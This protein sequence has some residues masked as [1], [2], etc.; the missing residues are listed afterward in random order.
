MP[1]T[2]SAKGRI[3]LLTHFL[4][5]SCRLRLHQHHTECESER[6]CEDAHPFW[7]LDCRFSIVEEKLRKKSVHSFVLVG[8]NPKSKIENYLMTLSARASTFGGIARPICLAVL[9]LMISSNFFGCS[10]GGSAG[11]GGFFVFF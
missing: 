11:G 3:L 2:L 9:R 8:F 5:P 7:I 10:T 6:D 4:Q 1:E